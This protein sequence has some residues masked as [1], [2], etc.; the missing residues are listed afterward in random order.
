MD[1][2][3]CAVL[4]QSMAFV[5]GIAAALSEEALVAAAVPP[6]IAVVAHVGRS[7]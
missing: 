3:A 7:V 6:F 5:G 2:L 1:I 4:V